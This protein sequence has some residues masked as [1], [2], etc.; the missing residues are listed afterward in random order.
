[1]AACWQGSD[2]KADKKAEVWESEGCRGATSRGPAA[3]GV[4]RQLGVGEA[5]GG[6][7]GPSSATSVACGLGEHC[8]TPRASASSPGKWAQSQE[9]AGRIPGPQ[10]DPDAVSLG[11]GEAEKSCHLPDVTEPMSAFTVFSQRSP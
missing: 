6:L 7:A 10:R 2:G 8:P 3:P 4:S 5:H 9:G 11:R 1:M